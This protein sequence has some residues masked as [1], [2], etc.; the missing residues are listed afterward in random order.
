[1]TLLG[2]FALPYCYAGSPGNKALFLSEKMR[3]S[4]GKRLADTAEVTIAVSTPGSFENGE[5]YFH[6]NK[7]RIILIS[8]DSSLF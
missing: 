3:N 7:T 2:A 8:F 6:I 4:P 1:M 5:A